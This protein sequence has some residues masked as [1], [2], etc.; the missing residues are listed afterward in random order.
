LDALDDLQLDQVLISPKQAES[1]LKV[2]NSRVN[3]D[4][5]AKNVSL[6]ADHEKDVMVSVAAACE[7]LIDLAVERNDAEKPN[8]KDKGTHSDEVRIMEKVLGPKVRFFM[9]YEINFDAHFDTV[10]LN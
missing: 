1:T 6:S 5:N 9:T 8:S 3:G 4:A 10:S 2:G 7:N